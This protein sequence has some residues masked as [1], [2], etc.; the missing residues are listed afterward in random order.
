MVRL[1]GYDRPYLYECDYNYSAQASSCD[2]A[3][4]IAAEPC[5]DTY[6]HGHRFFNAREGS[7][8]GAQRRVPPRRSSNKKTVPVGML[9]GVFNHGLH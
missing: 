4:P 6:V 8:K 5:V 3:L 7:T 2:S 9:G 1:H